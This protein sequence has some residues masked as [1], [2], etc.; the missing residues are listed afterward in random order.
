M[1][2]EEKRREVDGSA[3]EGGGDA[4][5]VREYNIKMNIIL[6]GCLI[7]K[8]RI[9]RNNQQTRKFTSNGLL[10]VMGTNQRQVSNKYLA[11]KTQVFTIRQFWQE[12]QKV[13][14]MQKVPGRRVGSCVPQL[15]TAIGVRCQS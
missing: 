8:E 2:K 9:K 11:L 14:Q 6:W 3:V 12:C 4:K 5:P 13:E 1:G 7:G 15:T 10:K